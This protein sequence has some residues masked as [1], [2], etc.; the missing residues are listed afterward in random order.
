MIFCNIRLIDVIY[1]DS[2]TKNGGEILIHTYLLSIL[3]SFHSK[4]IQINRHGKQLIPYFFSFL[5]QTDKKCIYLGNKSYTFKMT[6]PQT[7]QC[8]LNRS[9]ST[10]CYK[11]WT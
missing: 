1:Q 6:E 7:I 8:I 10:G 4:Y 3:L 2:I 5:F 9:K 11:S